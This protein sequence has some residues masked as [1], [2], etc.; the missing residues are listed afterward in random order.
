M[1]NGHS[2]YDLA[3]SS[4]SAKSI[5]SSSDS[6]QG[7]KDQ[8]S[9]PALSTQRRSRPDSQVRFDLPPETGP[10]IQEIDTGEPAWT[11][12]GVEPPVAAEP[13]T[14]WLSG[15][16]VDTGKKSKHGKKGVEEAPPPPPP[17]LPPPAPK[18]EKEDDPWGGFMSA[19]NKKKVK[20]ASKLAKKEE[21]TEL[22]VEQER[23][24]NPNGARKTNNMQLEESNQSSSNGMTPDPAWGFVVAD[25]TPV[26]QPQPSSFVR[27]VHPFDWSN[28]YGP[29]LTLE[30][31]ERGNGWVQHLPDRNI[32]ALAAERRRSGL[33]NIPKAPSPLPD[34]GP[35]TVID[36]P[37]PYLPDAPVGKSRVPRFSY[38]EDE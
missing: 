28:R 20:K 31:M 21:P 38:V 9:V 24:E 34:C 3:S 16:W 4:S 27:F 18:K 14:D 6:D 19:R 30:P 7:Q 33:N 26:R 36:E 15:A 13:T 10:N 23:H 11:E 32:I 25:V 35:R 37:Q 2:R 8:E 5:H 1:H 22:P 12:L 29:G 17:P